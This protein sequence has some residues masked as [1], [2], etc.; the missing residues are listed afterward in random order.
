MTC[1]S[2]CAACSFAQAVDGFRRSKG[3]W[4]GT[5]EERTAQQ[6]DAQAAGASQADGWVEHAGNEQRKAEAPGRS[7]RAI[8][9]TTWGIC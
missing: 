6:P 5:E 9:S 4:N 7:L 2:C 8:C 3:H 1:L